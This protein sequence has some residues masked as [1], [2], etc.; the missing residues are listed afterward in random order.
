MLTS[1]FSHS[2]GLH[3]LFNSVAFYSF[4]PGASL[5]NRASSIDHAY[6]L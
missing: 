1:T 5:A 6:W 3:F 4:G 2:T